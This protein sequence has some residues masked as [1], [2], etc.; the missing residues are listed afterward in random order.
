MSFPATASPPF[1][2]SS[3]SSGSMSDDCSPISTVS[4]RLSDGTTRR[5]RDTRYA[6][7]DTRCA[8]RDTRYATR[9]AR[10]SLDS[11]TAMAWFKR[12]EKAPEVVQRLD[13]KLLER[14]AIALYHKSS[15][16]SA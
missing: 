10:G 4:P 1:A 9:G 5:T 16:L 7:R 15:V 11:S 6:I 3:T 8:I 14:G 12:K 2:I 13:W